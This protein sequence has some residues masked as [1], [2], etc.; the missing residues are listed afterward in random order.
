MTLLPGALIKRLEAA[1]HRDDVTELWKR[2]LTHY[3]KHHFS[4][5]LEVWKRAAL[6]G[7]APS[8][9]RIGLLYAR[10]ESVMRSMPD[11]AAWY[12]QAAEKGFGSAQR[13]LDQLGRGR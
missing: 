12:R 6:R 3:D 9:Y 10:G 1:L 8:Q 4:K 7:H 11:A 5:A 2:G 13:K